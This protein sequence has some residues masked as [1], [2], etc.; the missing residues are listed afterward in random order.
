MAAVGEF[1]RRAG[2]GLEGEFAADELASELH[3]TQQSAAGQMDFA[4]QVAKRLPNTFAA[5]AAATPLAASM[6]T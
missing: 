3:L 5:L 1:A 6:N 2:T 4:T